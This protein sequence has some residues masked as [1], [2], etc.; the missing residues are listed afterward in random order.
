MLTHRLGFFAETLEHLRVVMEKWHLQNYF[1]AQCDMPSFPHRTHS[2]FTEFLD[3]FVTVV[4][5]LVGF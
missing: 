1:I 4:D 3:D 5:N 2:A